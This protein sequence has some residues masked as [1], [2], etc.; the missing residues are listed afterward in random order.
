M[1]HGEPPE[2]FPVLSI[3]IVTWNGWDDLQRCLASLVQGGATS[4]EVIIVDNASS[5]DI[6]ARV[7][8]HFPDARLIR[9]L[10]NTGHSHGVNQGI[11]AALGQFVLVL[12]S[13]TE[14][15]QDAFAKLLSF[16]ATRPDVGIVAPSTFN[17]D[18]SVQE[19]ARAFPRP[20]NGL[21]GRQSWLTKRFPNNPIARRY[22]MRDSA[23]SDRPY[24]VEQVSGACML[25]PR[26][27]Y[28]VVGPWDEGYFA[29][30]VDTDWCFQ[31]G[32]AGYGI[33]CV[34]A[35]R[36]VHHEQ[37]RAGKRR[38]PRRIWLFHYGAYRFYRKNMTRG[39]FD[40]RSVVALIAL[41]I[42]GLWQVMV[43]SRLPSQPAVITAS[44][45][46]PRR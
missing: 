28:E 11:A 37:N 20:L 32:R 9:N 35:A 33:Y 3:V 19:T 44:G 42:H 13:D 30:W 43:N 17:S 40:P 24:P 41:T 12:D 4:Y 8:R 39:Y 1:T 14:I 34:P 2:Q 7:E 5:E 36:I 10:S 27:L 45:E 38:S 25:F 46:A 31:V 15:G 23:N 21:F 6:P 29:Y 22:L 26:A 18:G 16:M